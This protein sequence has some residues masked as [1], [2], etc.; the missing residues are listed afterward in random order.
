MKF[1]R[2]KRAQAA[3]AMAL[4][5]EIDTKRPELPL[6]LPMN[7]FDTAYKKVWSVVFGRI[8]RYYVEFDDSL[9]LEFRR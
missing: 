7:I 8:G 2:L 4:R 1:I 9:T 5:T 6:L 3:G